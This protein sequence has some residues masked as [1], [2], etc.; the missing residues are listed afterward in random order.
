MAQI[1]PPEPARPDPI[2]GFSPG[3]ARPYPFLE[4]LYGENKGEVQKKLKTVR[5][6]GGK[7]ALTGAAA[8][9]LAR[10]APRLERL[11]NTRPDLRKFLK[12]DGGFYWRKIAGE[13]KASAHS[14]G[15]AIDLGADVAPYWRWA[16]KPRHQLQKS[17]SPEIV[18]IM[19]D[20]GF[21]WGGKWD[22]YDLMHFEYRPEL[23]CKGRKLYKK[24]ENQ[25]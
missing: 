12:V 25:N 8:E 4:A 15:L 20:A 1:Y 24:D 11:Y 18:E 23:I 14:Y 13:N 9:A 17:Y 21:I 5:L 3:R 16:K 7:V 2:D 10:V 6:P 22:K 19:E